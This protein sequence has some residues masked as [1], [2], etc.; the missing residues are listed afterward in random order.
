MTTTFKKTLVSCLLLS[1]LLFGVVVGCS[2]TPSTKSSLEHIQ[3]GYTNSYYFDVFTLTSKDKARNGI[4]E[5]QNYDDDIYFQIENAGQEK[6]FAVQ[7]YIDCKLASIIIDDIK[8]ETFIINSEDV[9]SEVY[10]FKL[11]EP[12]D[13]NVNHSMLAVL[14]AG[15]NIYT[16]NVE[17]DVTNQY[18]IAL[19]HILQFG[20]DLPMAQSNY[21]YE[22]VSLVTEYQSTG[23]LLNT[24]IEN[25]TRIIPERELIVHPGEDFSLQYQVGGYQDCETVAII[26]TIGLKQAQINN[27]DYILCQINNGELVHGVA[28][29]KAPTEV[30]EYEIM[31]WVIK[32]PFD[33]NKGNYFPL[34]AAH[35]FTLTVK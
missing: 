26:I 25:N 8:C 6:Q 20:E 15:S 29:L 17:F 14:I 33:M 13:T 31:G 35:R 21:S 28:N 9:A 22:E 16:K 23:L 1:I 34:D 4:I 10:S 3:S 32:N 2:S 27:Q 19:D 5:L 18:S 30:G 7:I 24:D 12:L 11:A